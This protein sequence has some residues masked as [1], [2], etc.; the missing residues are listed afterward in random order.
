MADGAVWSRGNLT[1]SVS[2]GAP[3]Q[4]DQCWRTTLAC[5]GALTAW[6]YLCLHWY[7]SPGKWRYK[8]ELNG[9]ALDL[10][11]FFLFCVVIKG[12]CW[13]VVN[14]IWVFAAGNESLIWMVHK[15]KDHGRRVLI[16]TSKRSNKQNVSNWRTDWFKMPLVAINNNFY[17]QSFLLLLC[18]FFPFLRH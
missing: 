17:H 2:A 16:S 5:R 6:W 3:W 18:F 1:K 4:N 8:D 14:M 7:L 15:C 13:I 12:M 11:L 9:P 10:M